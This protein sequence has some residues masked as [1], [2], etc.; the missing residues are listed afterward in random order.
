MPYLLL[1]P[2]W[3]AGSSRLWCR[4]RRPVSYAGSCPAYSLCR[5][6][7]SVGIASRERKGG[8]SSIETNSGYAV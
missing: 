1:S 3:P 5:L 6:H 7:G 8:G 2:L 4:P